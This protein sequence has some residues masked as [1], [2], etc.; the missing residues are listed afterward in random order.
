[1]GLPAP[2]HASPWPYQKTVSS[3]FFFLISLI[4]HRKSRTATAACRYAL[5]PSGSFR[6]VTFATVIG[7]QVEVG[8]AESWH[9]EL[10]M[11][12]KAWSR[13][14]RICQQVPR[15]FLVVTE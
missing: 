12:P 7:I 8:K 2:S 6:T 15:F 4:S 9:G 14:M 11:W 13:G 3:P 10:G 1:M 5:V